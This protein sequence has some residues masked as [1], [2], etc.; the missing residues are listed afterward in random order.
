MNTF[1]NSSA[2][3]FNDMP[4][5]NLNAGAVTKPKALYREPCAKCGGSGRYQH[6]SSRGSQ[7]F[8]CNGAGYH[9][10]KTSPAYRLQNREK[11]ATAKAQRAA[12]AAADWCGAF[13][14]EAAWIEARR[15]QFGFAQAMRVALDKF[16]AL[17]PGQLT[18]VRKCLA[19]DIA[20]D[21]AR[22]EAQAALAAREQ[23]ME[24]H[25]LETAFNTAK[26]NGLKYPRITL[27]GFN[28][29]PAGPH[30]RNPGAIYVVRGARR[31]GTYLGKVLAGRFTPSRDCEPATQ[32]Q[33]A[34]VL[35]DPLK[36]VTAYGVLTGSCAICSR[37]LTDPVSVA[38]GIGPVCAGR[39]GW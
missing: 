38:L 2:S 12:N 16:G 30:T 25:A 14:A 26:G 31:A 15:A 32:A 36:A 35:A 27:A 33:V 23:P 7:C 24:A 21:A 5:D 20:R 6:P 19:S 22:A 37:E 3:A 18:A 9:E 10:F 34:E 1:N 28:F 8:K 13:P 29:S 4:S 11:S 17:T 39:F